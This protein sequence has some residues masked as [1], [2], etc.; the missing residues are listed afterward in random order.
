LKKIYY[1]ACVA[2]LSFVKRIG[3]W[4]LLGSAAE[5]VGFRLPNQ[6][7]EGIARGNAFVATADNP[8]AIYYNPAGITQLE[9][10]NISFGSYLITVGVD[11][12]APDG[13]TANTDSEVQAAPQVYYT[14]SP[15]ES[16][17]SLGIGLYAPYGLGIDWG[18]DT[19]F[20]TKAENGSLLY[21][22]FN[23]VVAYE[24]SD[25]LSVAAGLT[26]NYSEVELQRSLLSG[27]IGEFSYEG[28]D[29]AIG[30]TFGLLYQ[31]HE[32]WS[33][34]LKY[35]SATKVNYDGRS[36]F[37]FSDEPLSQ[38]TT[39]DLTF[40]DNIDFG[41][42]YRPTPNWN[43]EVNIDWTNWDRLNTSTFV[44]TAVGDAPLPFEYE[45]SFF[46]EIGITRQLGSGYWISA[47]Y[48][49]AEN[50]VPDETLNPLNPDADLHL[51]S[52]GFGH[53]G[54]DWS[55]AV[56]YHFAYNG[57]RTVRGNTP[58]PSGETANGTYETLNHALNVSCQ[59]KF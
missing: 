15:K 59:F 57:G 2:Q 17:W 50:S 29:L 54:D 26:V 30:F 8:S 5:G 16:R 53:R 19:P 46:Y 35:R 44:G 55:W 34:G 24:A 47:G 36:T 25:S 52:L 48:I 13:R 28:D 20:S 39:A 40:P 14:Y 41:V 6:D 49:Y 33:I 37:G 18:S 32:E 38:P 1:C 43:F 7:P 23:T 27:G 22:T 51:G 42:S 10:S 58:E 56:G 31:P 45:S 11:F 9:G 3:G 12:T 4:L 21:A